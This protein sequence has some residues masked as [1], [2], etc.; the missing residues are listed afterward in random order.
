MPDSVTVPHTQV[1]YFNA[2]MFLQNKTQIGKV[3]EIFG[4][5]NDGVRAQALAAAVT[6]LPSMQIQM[7]SRN[8]VEN[9]NLLA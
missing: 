8:R 7:H 4:C 6:I 5:I 1:P 2:P 9:V 3:E